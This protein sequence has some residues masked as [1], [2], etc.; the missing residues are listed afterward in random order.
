M[1]SSSNNKM[2][3]AMPKLIVGLFVIVIIVVISTLYLQKIGNVSSVAEEDNKPIEY[4]Q[5]PKSEQNSKPA[6]TEDDEEQDSALVEPTEP[7]EPV[8]EQE[9]S[10]GAVDGENTTYEVTG[11]EA[12]AIRVE[13]SGDTWVGIRNEQRQE[14]VEAKVYTAGQTVEFDS[15]EDSYARIRLG[16]SKV[17]KIYVNDVELQ[18]T[19]DLVSQN[20]ILKLV[21]E[22]QGE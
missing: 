12:L 16:N 20:I 5:N 10:T 1:A 2:M 4:E 21:Q 18:Y 17:A 15:T 11:A 8:V 13:V 19:Q 7:T 6:V 22:Q 9:I 14:Q 3:E